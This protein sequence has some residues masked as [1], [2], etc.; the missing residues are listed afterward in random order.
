[1]TF[2]PGKIIINSLAYSCDVHYGLHGSIYHFDLVVRLTLFG[3][4]DI[5]HRLKGLIVLVRFVIKLDLGT[6]SRADLF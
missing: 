4:V 5:A 6:A 3:W 2:I 1:M